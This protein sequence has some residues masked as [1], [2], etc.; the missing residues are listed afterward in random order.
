MTPKTRLS[1]VT[2]SI[3]FRLLSILGTLAIG[4]LLLLAMVQTTADTT[5]Q[6]MEHIS[7]SLFP[8]SSALNEA[9]D[10]FTQMR[11]EYKDAVTLEDAGALI[12]ANK[13]T[14]STQAAL[15]AVHSNVASSPALAQRTEVL[16][17]QFARLSLNSQQTYGQMLASK[18]NISD[19]LQI[20][21]AQLARETAK[22]D[23]DMEALDVTFADQSRAE[24]AAVDASSHRASLIGWIALFVALLGC[25]GGWWVLQYKVVL[26]L[27]RLARRM[28]DIAEGDGDLT[29]RVEVNGHNELDEVGSWFNVFIERVEE[30]V[31][32]VNANAREIAAAAKGLA[33]IARET[34][35]QSSLQRDRATSITSSMSFIS[36]AVREISQ[37]T[38]HAARDAR[39]AEQN[40][41]TGG[42]TIHST[43]NTIQ[44][45]LAAN[46]ATATEI[47]GLG[48]SGHAIGKIIH[49]IDD[50]ADQTNLLALNASIESARAGEHGR[51]FAVVAGEVRRLADR[52]RNATRE[53]DHTV[54]AIQ[55]GTT[56]VVE[57]MRSSMIQVETSVDSARSAGIA[58]S[59]II[60]GSE[61]M[62]KMVTQIASASTEQ[63]AATQSVSADLLEIADIGTRT[64]SSSARAV[65]ACDRLSAMADDLNALVGAFKVRPTLAA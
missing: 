60:Q 42:N 4:Y 28:Q 5:H 36:T 1:L 47:E 12:D 56:R 41:H 17:Q 14:E 15:N 27:Q 51:G 64:T 45:L 38:Q 55:D 20:K 44:K 8:A 33:E 26:P 23:K 37:T 53:I 3:K 48:L 2:T 31:I 30:I 43:V 7:H 40:A 58:L 49:V 18:E 6:H 21:A 63:S 46:Q 10:A 25:L 65:D 62:Q 22:F 35:S 34:A 13:A 39:Q 57:A 50:I 11:K 29:D 52:T 32:R 54:R 16:Q 59:S 24:F 19:D 9:E 61:A